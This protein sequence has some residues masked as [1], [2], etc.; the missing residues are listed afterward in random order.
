MPKKLSPGARATCE[1]FR[2]VKVLDRLR[3]FAASVSKEID[4]GK[5]SF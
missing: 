2:D 3:G 4:L 1:A 5:Y